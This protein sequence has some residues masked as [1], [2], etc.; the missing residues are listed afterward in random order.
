MEAQKARQDD[1]STPRRRNEKRGQSAKRRAWS[2][3]T[4]FTRQFAYAQFADGRVTS[5]RAEQ[6][7]AE[8]RPAP[9]RLFLRCYRFT[10]IKSGR[11]RAARLSAHRPLLRG[12]Y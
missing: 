10:G 11:G 8:R 5:A 2:P 4:N 6:R 3:A 9:V 1:V 7:T 12:G